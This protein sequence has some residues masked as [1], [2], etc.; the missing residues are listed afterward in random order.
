MRSVSEAGRSFGLTKTEVQA[1]ETRLPTVV[2]GQGR[3][4]F[5]NCFCP[6]GFGSLM[7]GHLLQA[8]MLGLTYCRLPC[9]LWSICLGAEGR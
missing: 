3:F 6:G 8:A 5:F 7:L 9:F 4:C 1:P 2:R